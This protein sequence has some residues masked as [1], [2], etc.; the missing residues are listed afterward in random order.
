MKIENNIY[1]VTNKKKFEAIRNF[2]ENTVMKVFDFAY[3]MSYGQ[4]EH[5][6]HRSG[7]NINRKNGQIFINTFQ[8]KLA[9]LAIYNEFFN[10]SKELFNRLSKPDLDV[11][12]L[13]KWDDTDLSLGVTKF[14]IKSTKSY[15]NLLLL[16]T[17]DWDNNAQYK[18][19]LQ[20]GE[21]SHY[22]YIILVRIAEDGEAIMKNNGLLYSNEVDRNRLLNIINEYIWKYDIP[23]YLTNSDLKNIIRNRQIIPKGALLNGKILMDAENY[24]EETGNL[25]DFF[26][27][28]KNFK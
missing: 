13:G 3:E 19:N 7:G 1:T 28:V 16:E 20:I 6:D 22:D 12:G 10:L 4:G 8:G 27:L 5:R 23:G 2:K 26:N 15:G 24:Y 9:E 14:S 11:Y 21:T 18:P 25:R 17:N